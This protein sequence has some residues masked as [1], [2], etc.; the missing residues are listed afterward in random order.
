M[1]W[2]TRDLL[3]IMNGIRGKE[4]NTERF[5]YV[6]EID[7]SFIQLYNYLKR[8]KQYIFN[9]DIPHGS[10]L[11]EICENGVLMAKIISK[12]LKNDMKDVPANPHDTVEYISCDSN[13]ENG[14][15]NECEKWKF[16]FR[17]F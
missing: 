5:S 11:C 13:N 10:Y 17:R 4:V 9:R 15:L 12:A 3:E 1:L 6:F 2:T 16:E 7:L 8:H 14:I